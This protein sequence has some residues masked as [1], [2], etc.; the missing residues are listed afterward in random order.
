MLIA[1]RNTRVSLVNAQVPGGMTSQWSAN[2]SGLLDGNTN[3]PSMHV[4]TQ[5]I[6]TAGATGNKT[7]TWIS[8]AR[9]TALMFVINSEPVISDLEMNV[10]ASNLTP[11]VETNITF[12]FTATNNGPDNNSSVRVN[13]PISNGYTY[14]SNTPSAG[15]YN[16]V[17]KIWNIGNLDS[18]VSRTLQIVAFV[19]C[20][21]N[22]GQGARISGHYFD[23]DAANDTNSITVV[24]IPPGGP[25][26]VI[27]LNDTTSTLQ[28]QPIQLNV[29][30]NDLGNKTGTVITITVPPIGGS[31]QIGTGGVI[32]Y[33]PNGNFFGSDVF[34]YQICNGLAQCATAQVYVTVIENFTDP[35][36]EASRSKT[37][38]LPY[39]ENPTQIRTAFESSAT[40]IAGFALTNNVRSVT[41]LKIPYPGTFI[42]YDHWEDGYESDIT[43]KTQASTIIWGDGDLTNGV[44]PGYPTDILPAGASIVL[45]NT[46]SY[47]PRNPAQIVYDGR[48]KLFSS[49]DIAVS[50]VTGDAGARF[51]V[52]NLK[53]DIV[54]TRRFARSF[55]LPIGENINYANAYRYAAVLVR[56]QTNGT[57]VQFD[58]NADGII[59]ITTTLNEGEVYFYDGTGSNPGVTPGDVNNANDIKAGA[60]ILAS[61]PVGVDL[62]FGGIE[63]GT[64]SLRNTY[65]LPSNFNGDEYYNPVYTS[66][67]SA[68]VNILFY[69]VLSNS[70]TIDWTA[71][72]G[73]SGTVVV[74]ANGFNR[75]I[76]PAGTT[77][78]RFKSQGGQSFSAIAVVDAD[79]SGG[80]YDW[81]YT[82]IGA[83]RLTNYSS[84]A[85]APGSANNAPANNY[86]PI[87]VTPV[88]NT[89]IY[90]KYN[91]NM[92]E[93]GPS[94]SPCGLPFDVSFTLNALQVQ[95]IFNP[96][97]DQSGMGLYT[98]DNSKFAAVWGQDANVATD[99]SPGNDVGYVLQPKCLDIL[100]LANDD[101]EVTEPNIPVIVDVANNDYA[102]LTTINPA[103]VS[104]PP[105][106]LQPANGTVQVNGNGTITY[107]P[108]LNFT[109][110]DFFEYSI[111]TDPYP[112]ICDVALVRIDISTCPVAVGQNLISGRVFLEQLSD[113]GA[114]D[115][116]DFV[117]G[118]EVDI[119]SDNNCDGIVNGADALLQTTTTNLSGY[120]A[121]TTG[122]A[123]FA[124]DNFD[125][126]GGPPPASTGNSGN[127][128]TV[129]WT[130]NWSELGGQAQ[131]FSASPVTIAVDANVNQN[132]LILNGDNRGAIRSATFV[133]ATGASVKFAYRRRDLNNAG[134]ALNV[135]V[136][137]GTPQQIVLLVIDDGDAVGTNNFYINVSL[138][139]P[140]ANIVVNGVNTLSFVTNGNTANDDFFHIDNIEFI[141]FPACFTVQ[142]D[143][144]SS[145]GRYIAS[146]LNRHTAQTSEL[147]TC[148]TGYYLGVLASIDAIN[149]SRSILQDQPANIVVVGNDIGIP[150]P[151]SVSTTALLQPA[152]GSTIINPNGS[153]TY[154]PNQG[155]L[156]TDQFEYR[157]C[158]MEDPGVCDV[159]TVTVNV[160]CF[161]DALS[162]VV[163]GLVFFDYNE[164]G[165][166]DNGEIGAQGFN[167]ELYHDLN[168]N[169]VLNVGDTLVQT[170]SSNINGA[171]SFNVLT[172][173]TVRDEFNTNGSP[174]GNNGTANWANNWTNGSNT[175]L[176]NT[177]DAR[178][179]NNRLEVRN[180]SATASVARRTANLTGATSATLTFSYEPVNLNAANR[181][182]TIEVAASLAGPWTLVSSFTNISASGTINYSIPPA[183][184]G[185]TTSVR[186]FSSGSA[187][188]NTRG[189]NFDNVQILYHNANRNYIVQLDKPIP[190]GY[191]ETTLPNDFYTVSFTAPSQANCARNFG[192]VDRQITQPDIN[193]T[194]VNIPVDG[195]V[196]TNDNVLVGSTYGATPTLVSSPN[197]SSPSITMNANG[198]YTFESDIAGKYIYNVQVCA[199]AQVPPCP[200]EVLTIIVN[201][202]NSTSNQ[203]IAF[204]DYASTIRGV[205]VTLKTLT[206]DKTGNMSVSLDSSSVTI[207]S[208]P[209]PVN[210][211]SVSIDPVTGDITFTPVPSFLGEVTYTYQVCD[212][213]LPPLCTSANQ[214]ITVRSSLVPNNVI[215]ND[216]YNYTFS[217][218]PV[219]GNVILNDLDPQGDLLS[220]TPQTTTIPGVGTLNLLA[221]G[222]YTF[223]AVPGFYG[224]VSFPYVVCDNNAIVACTD[225]TLYIL[226]GN[227]ASHPDINATFVNLEIE[228]SVATNDKVVA[229]S[230][231]GTTT[232]TSSPGGSNPQ[233]TMFPDG[234]YIFESD[235]PGVYVY[236][237]EICKPAQVSPCNTETLTI[238]VKDKNTLS[239]IP[240][241]NTD[242]GITPHNTP[243]ELN[244]FGN[245]AAGSKGRTLNPASVTI[246]PATLPNPLTEGSLTIDNLTG[247]ISF[248]PV[249]GFSGQISYVYEVCDDAPVPQCANATQIITVLPVGAQNN[250]LA[251][252]DFKRL[253]KNQ[254]GSGN[255][256]DNDTD[257][258]GGAMSVTPFVSVRPGIGTLV[259]NS[260]G[261]YTF[262]PSN[263]FVG[264]T[265]YVYRVCDNG[266]PEECRNATLYILVEDELESS[267]DFN[268]TVT[269][270]IINGN[271]NTN[272]KV[273]TGM[274]Y[275][276][277]IPRLSNPVGGILTLNPDGTYDFESPN[278]GIFIYDIDI[279]TP[280]PNSE[281]TRNYLQIRVLNTSDT[282][283]LPIAN[284]DFGVVRGDPVSPATI[285]INVR[286]N[287]TVGRVLNGPTGR[288]SMPSLTSP[289]TDKNGSVFITPQG[290]VS[291]TPA[292]GYYGRDTFLYQ[293]CEIPDSTK[294]IYETVYITIT[295]PGT[296]PI[297]VATDDFNFT[298]AGTPVSQTVARGSISNDKTTSNGLMT[299]STTAGNQPGV[300]TLTLDPNGSYTYN[301]D[302]TF[303]GTAVFPY[304]LTD[305]INTINATIYILVFNLNVLPVDYVSFKAN[306]N[307]GNVSL[308]WQTAQE[309]NAKYF[310][311]Q[312]QINGNWSSIGSVPAYGN[313]YE[314]R[315]YQFTDFNN[316]TDLNLYRL[317]QV[318]LNGSYSY[319]P[320]SF[321]KCNSTISNS[322][323]T[324]PNP[325][326]K[327]LTI[328]SSQPIYKL[329]IVNM[330]GQIIYSTETNKE[331]MTIDIKDLAPGVYTVKTT[332]SVVKFIKQ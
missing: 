98:C 219:S 155:F 111:C 286:Q 47:N 180:N 129:N 310:E 170:Q 258:E 311:V 74:P 192:V 198:T 16:P 208:G 257:P 176:T 152:N 20:T 271:V 255:V 275:S 299:V 101:R 276:N 226:V 324:Y 137:R 312:K 316:I 121:F 174:S 158:S 43:I 234:N 159:A 263:G 67:A 25:C 157:V 181:T 322:I 256:L 254:I 84:I 297:I 323:V 282:N 292:A 314:I 200:T 4:A 153:I 66:N 162:N 41:S 199:P 209:D 86:N 72:S 285:L 289:T 189:A 76:I 251:A 142:V 19:R 321:A 39:P 185:A 62:I 293:V 135:I 307:N 24:P 204:N 1:A 216:D 55:V 331:Q 56:A 203:P 60:T 267:P 26:G 210:E 320:L 190:S 287:D 2:G 313:S 147:G 81:G 218:D 222:A 37:Y 97:G 296:P 22:Y 273:P 133:N 306:C 169:N 221:T 171:Y 69:N 167:V 166:Y 27:A 112:N 114:Y 268:V 233:I 262:T 248:T 140:L 246:I 124:A 274:E 14:I 212:K 244:T 161:A 91:G 127:D 8:N 73:G 146:S 141:Y 261:T 298:F 132:T 272:D 168:N 31:I 71:G 87:W 231:Y 266:T 291:Y 197:G 249:L 36:F 126:A 102:F 104:T 5:N 48:D 283:N 88:S 182:I 264:Q 179:A 53:S 54:D 239:N 70:I 253:A 305:G 259:L 308:I 83:Q 28:G 34:T 332:N 103:S 213:S 113:N 115:G 301:P 228:G 194:F 238:Y 29:A 206:N 17:T 225:A 230:S 156:G 105:S 49:S 123:T 11:N 211:G 191:Q 136:N 188:N 75:F 65:I 30:T 328:V 294:C 45:D 92:T 154:T 33:I 51:P 277:P 224:P 304:T 38:Y 242:I 183:L 77:G 89:T 93:T 217:T 80:D 260:D 252:D 317:K 236:D 326:T 205:P 315:N 50:K 107:T 229:G 220:I 143:P 145:G 327:E 125:G 82:L 227:Q 202:F 163:S 116:E 245:D 118:V 149:D 177:G 94:I 300:G 187:M 110:V 223:T 164:D 12:T 278:P 214:I 122:G 3:S 269:N 281:C 106:L 151:S 330:F 35:C 7:F 173:R 280:A 18:G 99:L 250:L 119:Y 215:A 96:S 290:L 85:W 58:Y 193:A 23:D 186:F 10:N 196:S 131:N 302:P 165:N 243:I 68:P 15:T 318:D 46:F 288:L 232:L 279:C 64:F 95:R 237:V 235:L 108:N 78:Y 44:A 21:G 240:F 319:S 329:E 13:V 117:G 9:A 284:I 195:N 325:A 52:Q 247:N 138:N 303:T 32:T 175:A 59:D 79:N 201:D 265:S 295:E 57:Q 160:G 40:T 61:E 148:R 100:V 184:I 178:V 6:A 42:I 139:V 241:A 120:Y 172:G 134:E 128:G 63:A 144:S 130:T 309:K 207:I 109:G 90:V 270:Q 150:N